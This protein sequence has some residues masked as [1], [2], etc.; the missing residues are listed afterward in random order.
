MGQR[1]QTTGKV[2]IQRQRRPEEFQHFL[3]RRHASARALNDTLPEVIATDGHTIRRMISQQK[4]IV[5]QEFEDPQTSSALIRRIE[6]SV[7]P[8]V[9]MVGYSM[10]KDNESVAILHTGQ[11]LGAGWLA[12]PDERRYD[13]SSLGMST[14]PLNVAEHPKLRLVAGASVAWEKRELVIKGALEQRGT[15]FSQ[16]DAA[17]HIL[18][19]LAEWKLETI[20]HRRGE[21]RRIELAK[22]GTPLDAIRMISPNRVEASFAIEPMMYRELR[23][24]DAQVW[25]RLSFDRG[26]FCLPP[27]WSDFWLMVELAEPPGM[28]L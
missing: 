5:F 28:L 12:F 27:E 25:F 9:A 13:T 26:L 22:T 8:G 23:K 21:P 19:H 1:V 14:L 16:S 6:S 11:G 4:Q 15:R 20:A 10:F 17:F 3:W 7:V 2:D 18:G 24:L